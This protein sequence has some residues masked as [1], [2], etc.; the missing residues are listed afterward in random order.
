MNKSES[1]SIKQKLVP[2]T[3]DLGA[4]EVRRAVPQARA[5]SIGPWVF[6]DHF[7]PA[8]LGPGKGMNVRPHPHIGIATVT[9]LFEG[10]IHH[11]DSVGSDQ[12]I[13]PGAVNLMVCGS[14][15]VHS[16][17]T[18]PEDFDGTYRMHGLQLWHALPD[19]E[20]ERAASFHH[21]P[22]DSIPETTLNGGA[23]VRLMIGEAFGLSSPVRRFSDIIYYEVALPGGASITL[24]AQT[25]QG[26]YCVDGEVAIDDERSERFVMSVLSSGDHVVTADTDARFAIVGGTSVGERHIRW[27]FVAS[28]MDKIRHASER[29]QAGDFPTIPGDSAEFIPL[30]ERLLF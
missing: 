7:G 3:H 22:A 6:F 2:K 1:G 17:R 27:N 4:F 13:E 28:D 26:L 15:M 29:W 21:Y 8:E 23:T 25:E 9:Y 5:R 14:G 24:P 30:P 18:Y 19:E 12:G 16:E 20:E 11:R 10:R